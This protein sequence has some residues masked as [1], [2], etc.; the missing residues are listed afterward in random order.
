VW[1]GKN[2]FHPFEFTWILE[3]LDRVRRGEVY[4]GLAPSALCLFVEMVLVCFGSLV[5]MVG[6]V[7]QSGAIECLV[8]LQTQPTTVS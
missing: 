4:P 2:A 5:E 8:T 1:T 6:G 3:F 7:L